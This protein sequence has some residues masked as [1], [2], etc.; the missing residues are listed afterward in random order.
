M[1]SGR[2]QVRVVRVETPRKVVTRESNLDKFLKITGCFLLLVIAGIGYALYLAEYCEM[3][4]G[5]LRA[6]LLQWWPFCSALAGLVLGL[7]RVRTD[8]VYAEIGLIGI[9]T[10][11]MPVGYVLGRLLFF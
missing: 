7:R 3:D 6:H 8:T 11:A 5:T 9:M 2:R 4:H 1:R 10:V